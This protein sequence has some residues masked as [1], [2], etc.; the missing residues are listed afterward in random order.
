[1]TSIK[2]RVEPNGKWIFDK[3]VTDCFEDMLERSIPQ[4]DVMR[5]AVTELGRSFITSNSNVTDIGCSKGTAIDPFIKE[6]KHNTFTLIDASGPMAEYC[7]NEYED[8]IRVDVIHGKILETKLP[9]NNSLALSILTIQFTPIENRQEI[10][11]ALYDSM[12]SG[13]A[14]ILV[15]KILGANHNLNKNMN[16]VYI[17]HKKKGGYTEEQIE[18]KRK[19]LEGVLVPV[20]AQWNEDLLKS[21]GFNKVDCFWR[22]MNFAGWVAVK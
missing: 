9:E 7:N 1:M 3:D 8:D 15:E 2:D 5:E 4:Y 21:T 22:W 11:S 20:T 13:G 10:F 18:R 19:S 12:A 16:Q 17:N 14:L 6:F